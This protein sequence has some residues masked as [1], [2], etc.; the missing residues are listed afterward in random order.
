MQ[1]HKFLGEAAEAPEIRSIVLAAFPSHVIVLLVGGVVGASPPP[2]DYGLRLALTLRSDHVVPTP[3]EVM[4]VE[5]ACY[6][7]L[8]SWLPDQEHAIN[9][10]RA[11]H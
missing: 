8:C 1:R 10:S 2:F 4:S 3:H 6:K 11:C 7:Q 9:H 5:V